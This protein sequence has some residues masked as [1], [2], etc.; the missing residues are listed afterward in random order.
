MSRI[1]K[2]QMS[3]TKADSSYVEVKSK[4]RLNLISLLSVVMRP[5]FSSSQFEAEFRRFHLNKETLPKYD[6]FRKML[7]RLHSL[8]VEP[9]FIRYTGTPHLTGS[10][11]YWCQSI[12]PV[13]YHFLLFRTSKID[14]MQ[15]RSIG[16]PLH[17][18]NSIIWSVLDFLT[19]SHLCLPLLK[20]ITNEAKWGNINSNRINKFY[21]VYLILKAYSLF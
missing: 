11:K 5:V 8:H 15:H 2:A 14:K 9:F 13:A 19:L 18:T 21:L 12:S 1:G 16:I 17:S 3:P 10:L 7:E 6:D 4:V 20:D